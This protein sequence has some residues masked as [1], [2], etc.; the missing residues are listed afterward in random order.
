[1]MILGFRTKNIIGN[2]TIDERTLII[3]A[4]TLSIQKVGITLY[5]G[6]FF[7]LLKPAIFKLFGE[8]APITVTFNPFSLKLFA[9]KLTLVQPAPGRGLGEP[10]TNKILNIFTTRNL[11]S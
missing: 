8:N 3:K 6:I 9:K 11:S 1:M 10:R 4:S 5:I 2:K 7:Q